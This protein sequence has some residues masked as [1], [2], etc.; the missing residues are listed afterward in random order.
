VQAMPGQRLGK[1]KAEKRKKEEPD[2]DFLYPKYLKF[3]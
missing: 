3:F 1:S 2:K